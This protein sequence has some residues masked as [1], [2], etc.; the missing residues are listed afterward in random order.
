MYSVARGEVRESCVL[1]VAPDSFVRIE[2][3]CVCRQLLG[4]GAW[5]PAKI[6]PN[7]YRPVMN[8]DPVPDDRHR[9]AELPVEQP[10]ELDN[11][12]GVNVL[13]VR[14]E[15]EVQPEASPL[16]TYRD[17]ADRRDSVS[18]IPAIV[19]RCLPSGR[20]S[21]SNCRS[22]HKPRF[23]EEDERCAPPSGVF[24]RRGNSSSFQRLI[25]SS[26]RSRA[27]FAGFCDVHLSRCTRILRMWST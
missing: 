17:G 16:R 10:Q 18:P 21:S 25:S 8:I 22:E 14:Q 7:D 13:V 15:V 6:L 4:N 11:V 26:S 3:R 1:R 23:V 19:D 5:M 24:F 20:E 27:R 12:L 9:P 2:V